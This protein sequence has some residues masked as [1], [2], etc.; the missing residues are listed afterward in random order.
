MPEREEPNDTGNPYATPRAPSTI[1]KV[2]ES[3][4]PETEEL[5]AFV[6]PKADYYLKRWGPLIEGWG[7]GAGANWAAF[8]LSGLWFGYRKMYKA[9]AILYGV[10]LFETIAEEVLFVGLLEL[11]EAPAIFSRLAGLAITVS[12]AGYG[13]RWYLAHAKRI[14]SEIGMEDED[15][16]ARLREIARRG[17]TS[18]LASF[19]CFLL[20]AISV[21]AVGIAWGLVLDS[22]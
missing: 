19:G 11:P 20:F 21:F 12:C 18:I 3:Q 10:I 1:A 16:E 22:N 7:R 8:F 14:I 17:G 6:G 5:R 4:Y 2:E 13:N 15:P 9:T